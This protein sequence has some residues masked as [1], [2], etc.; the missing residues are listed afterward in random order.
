MPILSSTNGV[1]TAH[2]RLLG[3]KQVNEEGDVRE[4]D[5]SVPIDIC[6]VKEI[7]SLQDGNEW[8]DVTEV[9]YIV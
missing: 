9:H 5:H 3:L 8:S 2:N 6:L 1:A 7:A 4:V